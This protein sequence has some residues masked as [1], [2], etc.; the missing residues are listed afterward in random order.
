[1]LILF[2]MF[3]NNLDDRSK[4]IFSKFVGDTKMGTTN[5]PNTRASVQKDLDKLEEGSTES[6]RKILRQLGLFSIL[7]GRLRCNLNGSPQLLDRE[8]KI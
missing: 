5:T 2:Y 6:C 4:Y 7:K 3:S 1:M 8:L